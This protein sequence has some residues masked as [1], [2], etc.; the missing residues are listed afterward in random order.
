MSES[1]FLAGRQRGERHGQAFRDQQFGAAQRGL[2][3][4]RVGVEHDHD[5]VRVALE[6]RR[7]LAR[8]RRALRRHRVGEP[9][10]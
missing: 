1:G 4:G 5:V 6:Q 9:P 3:A 7:V 8:E 10:R 2:L